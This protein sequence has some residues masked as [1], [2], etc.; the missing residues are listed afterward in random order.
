MA[1]SHSMMLIHDL[2][3]KD[4][5]IYPKEDSLNILDSKYDAC[6]SNNG[7]DTKHRRKISRR[8][9]YVR[10]GENYKMHKIYWCEGGLKLA[11]TSTKNVGEHD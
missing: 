6:M 4:P 5:C 3:N 1:L 11:E 8:T 10:N 7:K 9:N 2:L